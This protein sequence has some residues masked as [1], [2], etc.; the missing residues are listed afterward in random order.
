MRTAESVVLTDWPP[1][2]LERYT[3]IRRSL[4][5]TSIST[6]SASGSTATVAVEVWMRPCDSVAG[7]RCTRWT[8]DSNFIFEYTPLP[9]IMNETSLKPPTSFSVASIS[10]TF[11]RCVSRVARVHAVEVARE[12]ARLVAAGAGA[13][14]D[15]DVLVVVRVARQHH[16]LELVLELLA[17]RLELVAARRRAISL[18]LRVGLGVEHLPRLVDAVEH[19]EVLADLRRERRHVGVL[20]RQARVLLLVAQHRLVAE[21]FAVSSSYESRVWT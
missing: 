8:P 17:P 20:L 13:D 7:M 16:D 1:G 19:A 10:S 6:S 4:W 5:L 12:Q 9:L 2:P 15:D 21:S 3:S 11:Q 18:H 14:L